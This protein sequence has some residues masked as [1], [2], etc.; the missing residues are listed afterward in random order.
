MGPEVRHG[1]GFA[2]D[3]KLPLVRVT[4]RV[5]TR[6]ENLLA[7]ERK[8][9]KKSELSQDAFRAGTPSSSQLRWQWGGP[10]FFSMF[11]VS[12]QCVTR[13]DALCHAM[14]GGGEPM[15]ILAGFWCLLIKLGLCMK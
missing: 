8:R 14:G 6:A 2:R 12:M 11:S 3:S 4:T 5:W 9:G 10:I 1:S 15:T 13:T 7:I